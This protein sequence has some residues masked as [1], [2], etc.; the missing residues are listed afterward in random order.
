MISES[1]T[2]VIV[3]H[4]LG[5]L[6]KICDKLVWIDNGIIKQLGHPEEIIP[7]YTIDSQDDD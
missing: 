4:S 1:G 7:K 5:M 6:K 2:V 3:S